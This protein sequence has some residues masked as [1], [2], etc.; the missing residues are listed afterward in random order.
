M[1]SADTQYT[2]EGEMR[3]KRIILSL[4]FLVFLKNTNFLSQYLSKSPLSL[5]LKCCFTE[6]GPRFSSVFEYQISSRNLNNHYDHY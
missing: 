6:M 5:P 4:N 2:A 1:Q 3:S